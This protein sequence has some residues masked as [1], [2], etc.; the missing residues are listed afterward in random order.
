MPTICIGQS[1]CSDLSSETNPS[2]LAIF[3]VLGRG[4]HETQNRGTMTLLTR[5]T[6]TRTLKT[7]TTTRTLTTP[8]K[9]DHAAD[10]ETNVER[11]DARLLLGIGVGGNASSELSGRHYWC[12][13]QELDECVFGLQ[14]AGMGA[15]VYPKK[16]STT[17]RK[18]WRIPLNVWMVGWTT[19]TV[20]DALSRLR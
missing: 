9:E 17:T 4:M 16:S 5:T 19:V 7:P 14:K 10:K 6:R 2:M 3:Q 12:R 1:T 20:W 8:T 15:N 13:K 11:G 18:T